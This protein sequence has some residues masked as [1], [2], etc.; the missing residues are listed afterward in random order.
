MR[1]APDTKTRILDTGERLFAE[2]G[3]EATSLRQVTR[4]ASVNLAAVHYHFGSKLDLLRAVLERRLEAVNRERLA[5]LEALE[6]R[7]GGA[8]PPLEKVLEA[9]LAAPLRAAAR[10]PDGGGMRHFVVLAGRLGSSIGPAY[11]VFEEALREVRERYF[12][13]LRRAVPHV[14]DGDFGWRLRCMI[15]SMCAH[16]TAPSRAR[17][18]FGAADAVDDPEEALGQL[19]AFCAA[20]LRAAQDP[21]SAP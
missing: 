16:F 15:G 1:P 9:F 12:P 19:V 14:S 4:E 18:G 13:V 2:H 20:G 5:D 17:L 11:D 7:A 21:R 3:Y 6:T 8:S 10:E